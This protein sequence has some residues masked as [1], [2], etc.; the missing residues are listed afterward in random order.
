MPVKAVLTKL[1]GPQ[2]ALT[3]AELKN[4]DLARSIQ[5]KVVMNEL[6][7]KANKIKADL[8]QKVL[9]AQIYR[10][11]PT[12]SILDPLINRLNISQ[13]FAKFF[14]VILAPGWETIALYFAFNAFGFGWAVLGFAFAH[15]I[16]DW[17]VRTNQDGLAKAFS[18]NNLKSD[19]SKFSVRLLLA[20]AFVVPFEFFSPIAAGV[21][22]F[23]THV[24]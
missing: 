10:N 20:G 6:S 17:V 8:V 21:I 4:T 5:V 3:A 19:I 15:T 14:T 11:I 12:A 18:I 1:E 7:D 2:D 23:I 13:S 16:V 22:S 9:P 24:R